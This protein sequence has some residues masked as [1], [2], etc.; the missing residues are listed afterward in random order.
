MRFRPAALAVLLALPACSAQPDDADA[1]GAVQRYFA[2][3]NAAARAGPGAQQEFFAR[4]QHPDYPRD[5]ELGDTTVRLDPA[6]ST[7][8]PDPG[9]SPDGTVPRGQIW[10]IGVE[11]TTRSGGSTTGHQI[12]SQHVVLLDGRTYA[13]APC[14]TG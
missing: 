3:N 11:V 10:A 4:T 1:R 9:W 13:F 14:P 5:C 8:R 7:L 2:E 12:G 6:M